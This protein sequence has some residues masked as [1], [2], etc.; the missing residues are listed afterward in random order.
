MRNREK[1]V[2]MYIAKSE[3]KLHQY[4]TPGKEPDIE[5]QKKEIRAE[6][7]ETLGKCLVECNVEGTTQ[8]V[9]FTNPKGVTVPATVQ[10]F[11]IITLSHHPNEEGA[12]EI[13]NKLTALYK[14]RQKNINSLDECIYA[15]REYPWTSVRLIFEKAS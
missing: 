5:A 15:F 10:S 11:S 2:K 14:K 12:D 6:A 9:Q 13:R 1:G 4:F 7:E 3:N 8:N